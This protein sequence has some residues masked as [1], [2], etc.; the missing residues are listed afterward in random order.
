MQEAWTEAVTWDEVLPFQLTKIWKTWFGELP[1]LK[2]VK[3]SRCLKDPHS[4]EEWLTIHT[5]TDASEKAYAAPAYTRYEFEDGSFGTRLIAAKTRMAP[6]K[7]LSIPRL[8]LMGAVIGIERN[9]ATYWSD[10]CNIGYWIH[11]QSQNFKPFIAHRVGEI[12]E[13][14]NPDQCRYVLGKFNPADHGTRGLTGEDLINNK[15]WW[16]GLKFL[17]QTS[18]NWPEREFRGVTSETLKEVKAESRDQRDRPQRENLNSFGTSNQK[19]DEWRL[20]P[21]RFPNGTRR[22]Q[23][24][25]SKLELHWYEYIVGSTDSLKIV[26]NPLNNMLSESSLLMN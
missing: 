26:L 14:S 17:S 19:E 18:E 11:G 10:S 15:C 20:N 16:C 22:S 2:K 4:K 1:D 9:K 6:L 13:D 21:N 24:T 23:Q 25:S 12:H 5:F 3:I 8:E 7:A